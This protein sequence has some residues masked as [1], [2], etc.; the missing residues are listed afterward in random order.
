MLNNNKSLKIRQWDSADHRF[1]E[2][3]KTLKAK[4]GAPQQ[5]RISNFDYQPMNV[6]K[7]QKNSRYH[8]GRHK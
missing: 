2:A 6:F 5:T 8:V 3:E 7:L 4:K 1:S